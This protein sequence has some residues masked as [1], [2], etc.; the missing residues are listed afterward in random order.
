[1]GMCLVNCFWNRMI[2]VNSGF[3]ERVS[4]LCLRGVFGSG[5][6]VLIVAPKKRLFA[7]GRV[8]ALSRS[9][10]CACGAPPNM[11]MGLRNLASIIN[12][13]FDGRPP[14]S[15]GTAVVD[16]LTINPSPLTKLLGSVLCAREAHL[17][18]E[19]GLGWVDVARS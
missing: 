18:S 10:T 12:I 6:D 2:R 1:M 19:Q 16:P 15:L 8:T 11:K 5:F 7:C 3:G 13:W 4:S 17:F 9:S 14:V